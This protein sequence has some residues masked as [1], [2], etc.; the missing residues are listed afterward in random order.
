[1]NLQSLCPWWASNATQPAPSLF[2]RCAASSAAPREAWHD[3][4]R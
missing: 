1:M 4:H 2:T 3:G